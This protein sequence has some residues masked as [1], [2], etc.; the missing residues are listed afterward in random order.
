MHVWE[1]C[2][3]LLPQ[4]TTAFWMLAYEIPHVREYDG[5]CV[6][7]SDDGYHG[8]CYRLFWSLCNLF[9]VLI[10]LLYKIVEKS[11]RAE[12]IDSDAYKIM[13]QVLSFGP[14]LD[15]F[16]CQTSANSLEITK[17]GIYVW[18]KLDEGE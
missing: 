16:L 8:I 15:T 3:D 18:H 2:V 13:P 17:A 11:G 9:R 12:Y 14:I 10:S 4:T 5:D 7:P 1:I 6:R